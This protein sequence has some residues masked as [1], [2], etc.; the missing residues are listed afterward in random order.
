MKNDIEQVSRETIEFHIDRA[1]QMRAEAISSALTNL[2]K[3]VR[4]VLANVAHIFH[5]PRTR[6]L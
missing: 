2:A 3:S 6:Q 5:I 1:H 4:D